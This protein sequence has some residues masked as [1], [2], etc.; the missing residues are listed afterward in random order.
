M[1]R[2][3]GVV[4][5]VSSAQALPLLA[6]V[7]G[8][9]LVL[10]VALLI[11][12]A[13]ALPRRKKPARKS[14]EGGREL[15]VAAR[16]SSVEEVVERLRAKAAAGV[17]VSSALTKDGVAVTLRRSKREPCAFAQ[18]YLTGLF[19]FAWASD[20][21]LWHPSCAGKAKN[22]VCS[23]EIRRLNRFSSPTEGAWTPKS[24]I[25]RRPPAPTLVG[26]VQKLSRALRPGSP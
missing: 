24:P 25:D 7:V 1:A 26:G 14:F 15:G 9:S 19:E 22:A 8:A 16:V 12:R 21:G 4:V 11:A 13:A 2:F 5:A 18:G 20:V 17:F 23:Y 10:V 6:L 3:V